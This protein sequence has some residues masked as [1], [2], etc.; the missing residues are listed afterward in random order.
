MTMRLTARRRLLPLVLVLA[1]GGLATGCG[2]SNSDSSSSSGA[3]A[4]A[5]AA[6][7]AG[8]SAARGGADSGSAF[9]ASSGEKAAAPDA[10]APA[11]T[12]RVRTAQV[13]I[14]VPRLG[15]AVAK[16]RTAAL[17]L[18]GVVSNETT[19]FQS[20]PVAPEGDTEPD[21]T[22]SEGTRLADQA[23]ASSTITLRV[24]EPR[25]DDAVARIG[26]VG[27]VLDQSSTSEDVTANIADLDSRVKSQVSSVNRIRVLM[28]KATSLKDVVLIE[29]ELSSREADL[30]ALQAKQR[31]L[32]DQADLATI[33]V[34]VLT[35]AS[36]ATTLKKDDGFLAGLKSG[37]HAL[38]RSTEV[39][40]TV[41]G[42][43]L[44]IGVLLVVI[45]VPG[46]RIYRRFSGSDRRPGSASNPAPP[47]PTPPAPSTH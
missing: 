37:W 39:A 13:T 21:V 6:A 11:T 18:G 25:M 41:V 10:A 1:V 14:E 38:V 32:N 12:R 34:S 43:V 7:S 27:K 3:A 30:E 35:P 33:T 28:D 47:A 8:G 44:P 46:Y 20:S 5:P 26:A 2:A 15:P 23:G 9:A 45:G 19:Q 29:G 16:V 4:D 36:T 42:A 22:K 40:L 24:P 31:V 17:G